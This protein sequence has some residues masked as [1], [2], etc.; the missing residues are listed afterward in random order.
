LAS[1]SLDALKQLFCPTRVCRAQN[2]G[3]CKAEHLWRLRLVIASAISR[4]NA[5][6]SDRSQTFSGVHSNGSRGF[7]MATKA[8]TDDVTR[9]SVIQLAGAALS[10]PAA[11]ARPAR[12]PDQAELKHNSALVAAR[13]RR[14]DGPVNI[15]W[16]GAVGDDITNDGPA[17]LAAL[18]QLKELRQPGSMHGYSRGSVR[19]YIPAGRYFLGTTTLEIFHSLVVEGDGGSGASGDATVLRW[20]DN[21]TGIRVHSDISTG[22]SGSGASRG[23][24]GSGSILRGLMLVGGFVSTESES[25]GIHL[26]TKAKIED[27]FIY[28]FG[29]DG[30]FGDTYGSDNVNG[31]TITNPFVLGCRNGIYLNHNDANACLISNPQCFSNRCYGI[32][33][34]DTLGSII[35]GGDLSSNGQVGGFPTMVSHSGRYF[36][37]KPNQE[38]GASV[39]APPASA[40]SNSWWQYV[41]TGDG[42]PTASRPA[43]VNGMAVHAGGCLRIEGASEYATVIGTYRELDQAPAQVAGNTLLTGGL[44]EAVD[45]AGNPWGG[46]F[47]NELGNLIAP[48][49][50]DVKGTLRAF[51]GLCLQP[52]PALGAVNATLGI[53][54]SASYA[55]VLFKRLGATIGSVF[56]YDGDSSI[57]LSGV[58]GIK[59]Q[60]NGT[61]IADVTP[62]AFNLVAGKVLKVN[63]MQVVGM[64]GATLPADA[65]DLAS[66]IALI[67]AIKARMVGHGLVAA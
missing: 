39:N 9:R 40:T 41:T 12:L 33:L 32:W 56:V 13:E 7:E 60:H 52:D 45:F 30:I 67:N 36:W 51:E 17:F 23:Y 21:I 48:R 54:T 16:F 50:M 47:R 18:A 11:Q 57:Y 53:D 44:I 34:K 27:V 42:G 4:T 2:L 38:V 20:A 6:A 10:L 49:N 37:V 66:A 19:L 22:A 63:G 3:E 31:S 62:T 65:T 58:G 14:F 61:L 55:T 26:R 24:S 59:F 5:A 29:G 15:K 25:H 64:R 8:A 35:V 43:W 46:H 28:D 1:A